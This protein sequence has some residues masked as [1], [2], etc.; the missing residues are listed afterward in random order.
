MARKAKHPPAETSFGVAARNAAEE[1][2]RHCLMHGDVDDG[3]MVNIV[4]A[5]GAS[6]HRLTVAFFLADLYCLG[7]KDV[8]VIELGENEFALCAAAMFGAAPLE[9]V[10][11]S[12]AR[13]L[14]RDVVLWADSIGFKP[15]KDFAAVEQIFGNVSAD[16]CH[17]SFQFGQDGKPLYIVGPTETRAQVRRRL[18]H[19]TERLGEE[20]FDYVIPG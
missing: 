19:L 9:A 8:F 13:K 6:Q 3:G 5:R 10:E 11:P 16:A 20:G 17:A 1:P 15:H 12:F 7:I 14:L 18:A 2:I 4:V